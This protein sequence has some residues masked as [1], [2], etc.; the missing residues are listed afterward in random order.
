MFGRALAVARC[1]YVLTSS[2][3]LISSLLLYI[4][5]L[6]CHTGMVTHRGALVHAAG[7]IQRYSG[8]RFAMQ[9]AASFHELYVHWL[10]NI[11]VV[12]RGTQSRW[13]LA[14]LLQAH[15]FYFAEITPFHEFC[16]MKWADFMF[17]ID[18][19]CVSICQRA[20]LIGLNI[21]CFLS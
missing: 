1:Y 15:D 19:D 7:C 11:G 4:V 8:L 2:V 21:L 9:L 13:F 10:T 3:A 17:L 5:L 6:F 12:I 14:A 18:L 16:Q 20:L